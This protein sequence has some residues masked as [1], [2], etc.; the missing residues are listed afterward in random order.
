M[1]NFKK[2]CSWNTLYW[3]QWLQNPPKLHSYL[4]KKTF[5]LRK[6]HTHN[7][8]ILR[9]ADCHVDFASWTC[10]YLHYYNGSHIASC[11]NRQHSFPNKSALAVRYS[12]CLKCLVYSQCLR[13]LGLYEQL[14][15]FRHLTSVRPSFIRFAEIHIFFPRIKIFFGPYIH[16]QISTD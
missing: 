11:A 3:E 10:V 13:A 2:I 15:S 1:K 16:F 4:H 14:I 8:D 12:V 5:I 9:L 6:P 7:V